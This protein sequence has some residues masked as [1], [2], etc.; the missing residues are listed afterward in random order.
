MKKYLDTKEQIDWEEVPQDDIVEEEWRPE[1]PEIQRLMWNLFEHPHTS[2]AA[3]IV[4]IISVSCIFLSTIILTLDTMPYFEDHQDKIMDQFAPF[5]IIE[6]I[7]MVWFTFE[8]IIRFACCP[9]KVGFCKKTMN[10]IDLLGKVNIRNLKDPELLFPL[11]AAIVPYFVTVILNYHGVTEQAL[12]VVATGT[13]EAG[14]GVE[15]GI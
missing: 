13:E 4:G 10:W 7:Y 14:T 2:I 12:S 1:A 5:V 6:A 3:R 11:I 15:L 9:S 8:F